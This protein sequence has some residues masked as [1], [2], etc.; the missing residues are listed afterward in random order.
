MILQKGAPHWHPLLF[1]ELGNMELILLISKN[2]QE[3]ELG[4][5]TKVQKISA[6]GN[7]KQSFL[8]FCNNQ[9]L[10]PTAK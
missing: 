3:C 4:G 6:Y 1:K 5:E 7:K 10:L 9:G 2:A 8:K